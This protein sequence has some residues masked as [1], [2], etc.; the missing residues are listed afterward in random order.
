VRPLDIAP[1]RDE[2]NEVRFALHDMIRIAPHPVVVTTAGYFVL[3]QLDGQH[4]GQDVQLAFIKQFG[5]VI[6]SDQVRKIVAQLD[7]ALLLD[8]EN[9]R[10]AYQQRR[11]A[12]ATAE[13]RDNRPR[14]VAAPQL[15]AEI[16]ALLEPGRAAPV[17]E[18]RGVVAPHLDYARGRPCYADAYA[19]LLH[20][21]A[22]ERYVILGTNHFG[23][24]A[25]VV[26]T[27]KDFETPLGRVRTDR[28]FIGRLEQAL[29]KSL[30]EH[31]FDHDVEHSVELQVQIL[32]VGRSGAGFSIVPLLCPDVCG[33]TGTAPQ[34]GDGPDLRD[35][36]DTLA[37]VL[38]ADD[39]RTV[40]IA[41]A[42][43]S[44]VG[45][46]FGDAEAATLESLKRV[47]QSDRGL[48]KL[49]E[50]RE[51]DAFVQ[52]L[53]ENGNPTHICSAG[54]IYALLRAL[55][56]QECRLLR[57]HQ[58]TDMASDTHVTCAAAVVGT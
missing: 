2:R 10:R 32:Q 52:R 31:E 36:A 42:D 12:Y 58:A 44:H 49:L 23:R 41:G 50:E 13:T 35:F 9:F 7:Q 4:T 28:E 46:R 43:L 25:S 56:G 18:L 15:L 22:A 6:S 11:H 45:Q 20:H 27:T 53:R 30:C 34:D 26:A 54:C 8:S 38:A 1:F 39:R 16:Q 29:G 55:P 40:L 14:S 3:S 57:Y 51:E 5:Q 48:L 37:G 33:P 24:S 21:A 19:T 47:E 17:A